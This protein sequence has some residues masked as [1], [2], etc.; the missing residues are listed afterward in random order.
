MIPDKPKTGIYVCNIFKEELKEALRNC[1][2]DDFEL[3]TFPSVCHSLSGTMEPVRINESK[4]SSNIIYGGTCLN[5]FDKKSY[6][7]I[8][9][10]VNKDVCFYQIASKSMVDDLLKQRAYLITPGWLKHWKEYIK[11]WG[12][13]REQVHEYFTDSCNNLVLLDTGV[14]DRTEELFKKFSD[15][16]DIPNKR[17]PVGLDFLELSLQLAHSRIMEKWEV[18][19]QN[20][21]NA[22]Y[23][24]SLDLIR[25]VT[26]EVSEESIIIEVVESIAMLFAPG[27]II[28]VPI[29]NGQPGVPYSWKKYKITRAGELAGEYD[30]AKLVGNAER[31]SVLEDGFILKIVIDNE[32]LG[33]LIVKELAHPEY[34]QRYTEFIFNISTMFNLVIDYSRTFRRE[35]EKEMTLAQDVLKAFYSGVDKEERIRNIL[36]MLKEYTGLEIIAL[37][38]KKDDDYPFFTY[39]GSLGN[40]DSCMHLRDD[41]ENGRYKGLCG[42]VISGGPDSLKNLLTKEGSFWT[43]DLSS[44]K[45]G[46][47]MCDSFNG[48]NNICFHEGC[49]TIALIPLKTEGEVVGLLHLADKQSGLLQY[50]QILFLETIVSSIVS[51]L[52]RQEAEDALKV[53]LEDKGLLLKEMNHRVKN[54]L[55]LIGS[56]LSLQAKQV[57]SEE[58]RGYLDISRGRIESISMIHDMLFRGSSFVSVD[59][60]EYISSITENLINSF[61]VDGQGIEME[62]N[63]ESIDLGTGKAI[64]MGLIINE[65][66]TNSFKYAFLHNSKGKVSI[67]TYTSGDILNVEI[68]DNGIGLPKDMD[69]EMSSSLGFTLIHSLASQLNGSLDIKSENGTFFSFQFPINE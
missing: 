46:K 3:H 11:M 62:T 5:G 26:R 33:I 41:S 63:L 37:R 24:M 58:I 49:R 1:D 52:K 8:Y 12:F 55:N 10:L 51:L 67:K 54:N 38:L 35:K 59:L 21:L 57:E 22:D 68:Y 25:Q 32:V 69:W 47:T 65:V 40:L 42:S 43:E 20:E 61:D 18:L 15:F 50:S 23:Y 53:S 17:I 36:W 9:S 4:Y 2:F 34:L 28:Y 16:I 66:L 48:K 45:C 64:S 56:L 31:I 60:R 30:I 29:E 6:K 13:T 39:A 7:K 19:K 44:H 14:D 27:E